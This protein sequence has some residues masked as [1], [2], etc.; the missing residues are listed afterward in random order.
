MEGGQVVPMDNEMFLLGR[1]GISFTAKSGR[2][3][4]PE[5]GVAC[6]A[7]PAA[8]SSHSACLR[9]QAHVPRVGPAPALAAAPRLPCAPARQGLAAAPHAA[10]HD[11]PQTSPSSAPSLERNRPT[12]P[13]AAAAGLAGAAPTLLRSTSR[14][15]P[16][17]R[18]ASAS[19]SSAPTICRAPRRRW[20]ARSASKTSDGASPS[21]RAA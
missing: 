20:T 4:R 17:L 13:R 15:P 7:I 2:C 1:G 14:W 16:F 18:R 21:R 19:Q 10:H 9:A 5:Y 6:T 3:E 12:S 8:G 11:N